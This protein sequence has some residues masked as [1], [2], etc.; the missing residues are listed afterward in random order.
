MSKNWVVVA[1]RS[2]AKIFE[3]ERNGPKLHLLKTI[4]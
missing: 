3:I 2:G 4:E 1:G